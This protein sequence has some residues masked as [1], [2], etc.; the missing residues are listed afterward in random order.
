MIFILAIL[1]CT[2]ST[3]EPEKTTVEIKKEDLVVYSALPKDFFAEGASV[4]PELVSLGEKLFNE[5]SL[6][7]NK[8]ISC[9][10]C[11]DLQRGGV[12]GRQFSLGNGGE[13]TDRNSPT[14]FNA[15]GHSSQFWDGRAP[16]VERQA[17]GP[18]LAAGEMG[19]PNPE[20]VVSVLKNN[21][22]Y[23]LA[24][25][26]A[27]PEQVDPLTFENVGIAIGAYERTLSTPS[28]WDSFLGGDTTVLSDDEK[29]G[30]LTFNSM[31]CGTCHGGALLGGQAIMKAGLVYP[32]PNQKDLG[33]YNVTK[34]DTDKLMFK[35][36]SLRNVT[37]TAPYF[38]DGSVDNLTSAIKMM[39]H[40]QLGKEITDEE[41]KSIETWLGS[42][43]GAVTGAKKEE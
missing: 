31:G 35:V 4:K 9:N 23:V 32:W 25:K 14:V 15:A 33:R 21:E 2:I 13:L 41:A 40:H 5:K 39:G 6:S 7:L 26:A 28:R 24:F 22:E 42:T 3:A 18:I 10:S 37:V 20:A 27:F 36:P 11:H 1:G 34:S 43:A 19:M 29:K 38:H 12:D 16:D 17:L 8:D 30:F